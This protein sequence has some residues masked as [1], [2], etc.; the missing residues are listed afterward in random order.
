MTPMKKRTLVILIALSF[1]F[2]VLYALTALN[3]SS[4]TLTVVGTAF[5][6]LGAVTGLI[7]LIGGLIKQA[8]RRQWGWFVCTILF[9]VLCLVIYLIVVPDA[10]AYRVYQPKQDYQPQPHRESEYYYRPQPSQEREYREASQ[11]SQEREYREASQPSQEREYREASQTYQEMV[12]PE[13]YQ[14]ATRPEFYEEQRRSDSPD[15]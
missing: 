12:Q 15:E 5:S 1:A 10:L 9:G 2:D 6:L 14:E 3:A 13:S 8:K 4:E 11:P 7:A